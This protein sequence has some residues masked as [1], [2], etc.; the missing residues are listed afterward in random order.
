MLSPYFTFSQKRICAS[1]LLPTYAKEHAKI[2]LLSREKTVANLQVGTRGN[3][4]ILMIVA[5]S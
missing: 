3:M 1:F 4:K 5:L 2:I